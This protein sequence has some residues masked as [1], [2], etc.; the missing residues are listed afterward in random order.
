M[1]DDPIAGMEQTLRA[2]AEHAERYQEF[3]AQAGGFVGEAESSDGLLRV[4]VSADGCLDDL[5]IDARAMRQGSETLA[6]TILDLSRR[7][8]EDLGRRFDEAKD[9]GIGE[10]FSPAA[11]EDL[12]RG[13]ERLAADTSDQAEELV[14]RLRRA[15]GG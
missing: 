8:R 4:R 3:D 9:E 14:W 2:L 15:T 12:A 13:L 11:T 10:D 6:E 5:T 7:A 1:R